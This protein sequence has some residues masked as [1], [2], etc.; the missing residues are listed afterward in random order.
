MRVWWWTSPRRSVC[1]ALRLPPVRRRRGG[2]ADRGGP[3][4]EA[5]RALA[6]P[7]TRL[8]RVLE[9]LERAAGAAPS[10][11]AAVSG[12]VRRGGGV[13]SA[14]A[15]ARRSWA[16]Q[17]APGRGIKEKALAAHRR[18]L[19]RVILPRENKKQVDEDLG[20]GLRRAVAVDYVERIDE[21]LELALQP[22]PAVGGAAAAVPPAGRVS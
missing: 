4:S 20:D 5:L 8:D 6:A 15:H 18:G 17:G 9:A 7:D 12:A 14:G 19:A 3:A 11:V 13:A 10:V 2:P 22:A 1:C 16:G 21:L